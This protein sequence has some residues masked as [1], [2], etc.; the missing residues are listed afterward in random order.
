MGFAPICEVPV[1]A[2]TP[3]AHHEQLTLEGRGRAGELEGEHGL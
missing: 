2:N 3:T 1:T